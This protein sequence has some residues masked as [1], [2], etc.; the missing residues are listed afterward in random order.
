MTQQ[1]I[2]ILYTLIACSLFCIILATYLFVRLRE[3]RVEK[4]N[5]IEKIKE[6]EVALVLAQN[7]RE[8]NHHLKQGLLEAKLR[9]EQE[10]K[11][12]GEKL[13]LLQLS[14]QK[15]SDSFKAISGDIF[16]SQSQSFLELATAKFEKLQESAKG[17]FHLKQQSIDE[18]VK[19]IK[20]SLEK[21]DQKI[22]EVEKSRTM[23]YASL[24]E[25]LKTVAFTQ[26]HLQAETHNLVKA[27]KMPHVRGRWGEIQLQ[28][29]VEMAGMVEYCD[30]A[31]QETAQND[32]RSFRPDMIVKLP[33]Q[34]QVIVD[35]KAPL[36]AYLESLECGDEATRIAR[37]KEHAKQV[38]THISQLGAKSY[39]DQFQEV[40]EFVVLFLP[41]ET[42][43]SAALEQDP[44]LIEC[45]VEQK[46][47]LATPTT[48]IALLRS[49][50]YGWR[51]EQM[52]ENA[53]NI[54]DLGKELYKRIQKFTDHFADVRKG[55]ESAVDA[56]NRT[57][58]SLE[59]RV[60][61]TARKFKD[62]GAGSDEEI[63][64]L[65]EVEKM[66]RQMVDS[67]EKM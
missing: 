31:R 6:N 18:L 59:G 35:S 45:G 26:A 49:V 54:C 50:A 21:V 62:L 53:K 28:R 44:T 66:P 16:K 25:Q 63:P 15:L 27:L 55:L 19:P 56:Y 60:L 67:V 8:E 17:V 1:M 32:Q 51:Q 34:R 3:M 2:M 52:T 10:K 24:T 46:V 64:L 22:A 43:F 65:P 30:F 48:L 38:R 33:N 20:A 29:V 9:L 11:V 37:L 7:L 4:N 58:G 12:A 41:G 14:Q 5:L 13:E 42:F 57:I 40:P 47:I 36:Q 61:V 39:W 23:A